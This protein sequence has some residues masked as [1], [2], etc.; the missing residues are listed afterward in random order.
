MKPGAAFA[1]IVAGD[2]QQQPRA[3]GCPIQPQHRSQP[4]ACS[5][6]FAHQNRIR[7][8]SDI[9]QMQDEGVPTL[10]IFL[11]TLGP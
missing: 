2:Q 9:E 1:E 11:A 10:A 8:G 6:G 5:F 7:T 3:R 4:V